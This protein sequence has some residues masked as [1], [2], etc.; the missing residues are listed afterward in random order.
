[1]NA[2]QR[3]KSRKHIIYIADLTNKVW[4]FDTGM[5][6]RY[7]IRFIVLQ[8]AYSHIRWT[9]AWG[10]LLDEWKELAQWT[11]LLRLE[12]LTMGWCEEMGQDLLARF[13][14]QEASC[15]MHGCTNSTKQATK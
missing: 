5:V 9:H 15:L 3:T 8:N 1:M 12:N 2:A 7:E 6:R 11:S 10:H 14:L 4:R 13:E